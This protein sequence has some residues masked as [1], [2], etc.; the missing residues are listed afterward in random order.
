MADISGTVSPP[1]CVPAAQMQSARAVLLASACAVSFARA[2]NGDTVVVIP[3]FCMEL[4]VETGEDGKVVCSFR[5]DPG[6]TV[7]DF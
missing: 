4:A 1:S 7:T 3:P 5:V 6:Q 2:L